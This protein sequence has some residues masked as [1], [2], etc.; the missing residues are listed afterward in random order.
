MTGGVDV[1][2]GSGVA[3]GKYK[4]SPDVIASL[5]LTIIQLNKDVQIEYLLQRLD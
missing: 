5:Y 2:A 4:I 1:M 3:A